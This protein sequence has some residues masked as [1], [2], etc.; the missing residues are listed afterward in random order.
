MPDI[1]GMKHTSRLAA[2][3]LW[4][5][6]APLA[7]CASL[8][9]PER[10]AVGT[11]LC[12][13]MRTTEVV[14]MGESHDRLEQ[15]LA[16]RDALLCMLKG[17][18]KVLVG[19]EMFQRPYQQH[20]DDYVAGRIDENEML[21][22]TEYFTRWNFDWTI[23]APIWR[24]AKEHGVR[25]VALNVP[26][27]ISTQVGRY[28]LDS[29]SLADRFRVAQTVDLTV[30]SHRK[31]IR[32]VFEGGVHPMP[33]DRIDKLYESQTLWDETM[34]ESAA[35]A[36][37]E[38]GE[39]ARMLVIAGSYHIQERDGIPDRIARRR[40]G[41][42]APFVIVMRQPGQQDEIPDAQLGD[43]VLR[44][45]PVK[46]AGPAKLG[47]AAAPAPLGGIEVAMVA[48]GGAAE[49]AGLQ[50]GD[51]I[52]SIADRIVRDM[53]DFRY[54]LD[55]HDPQDEVSVGVV[56]DGKS[57]TLRATLGAETK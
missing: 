21:R 7:G 46:D 34:A 15:H 43:V 51:V 47:I 8:G 16:Q 57:L 26:K 40:P 53:T 23:Y 19:M 20:L 14:A 37:E 9:L 28:G 25:I 13:K 32:A 11:D 4:L 49:R 42:P 17:G 45:P 44:V 35:K 27:E 24:T 50:A 54:I 18:G 31:R 6:A 12:A 2:S 38:A 29:L 39:G 36:L 22:R 52:V 10:S 5:A 33:S 48:P 30:P 56:R 1:H 55:A 41:S 3:L